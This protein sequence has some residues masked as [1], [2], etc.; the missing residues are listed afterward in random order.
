MIKAD[1]GVLVAYGHG[2]ELGQVIGA[3]L[4]AQNGDPLAGVTSRVHVANRRWVV[5]FAGFITGQARRLELTW[6]KRN[7]RRDQVT[8]FRIKV[9]PGAFASTISFPADAAEIPK[10]NFVVWGTSSA[11][12]PLLGAQSF[13]IPRVGGGSPTFI[14][15]T[16]AWILTYGDL[17]AEPGDIG[18]LSVTITGD[19]AIPRSNLIVTGVE[20]AG[21]EGEAGGD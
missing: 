20:D 11:T 6:R 21:D 13:T 15:L 18:D 12:T 16:N 8:L 4:L 7:R 14:Q 3:R 19:A 2:S 5:S 1:P 9:T 10:D 17:D